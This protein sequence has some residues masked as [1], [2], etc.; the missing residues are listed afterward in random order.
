MVIGLVPIFILAGFL[1]SFVTRYTEMP[2][3]LSLFIIVSSFSFILFYFV[4]YPQRL[5]KK[6]I[7][8]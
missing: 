2:I 1:E 5:K 8:L 4:I 7:H 3:W 6:S